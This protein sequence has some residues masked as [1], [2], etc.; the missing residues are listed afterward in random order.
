MPTL[1]LELVEGTHT[2]RL[3]KDGYF[4]LEF[5]ITVEE[6]KTYDIHKELIPTNAFTVVSITLDK[7]QPRVGEIVKATITVKNN[8][9]DTRDCQVKLYVGTTLINTVDI[10]SVA[11]NSTKNADIT[12]TAPESD[13]TVKAEVYTDVY[14]ELKKTDEKS[15]SLAIKVTV[16]VTISSEPTGARVYVDGEYKG[17]T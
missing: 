9:N 2:I 7:E 4:P 13:T 12:F 3:E 14:G 8:T 6:G 17:T 10:T 11:P 15:I 16:M 1:T 5:T